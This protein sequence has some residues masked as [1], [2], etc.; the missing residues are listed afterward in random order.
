MKITDKMR[1]DF[2]RQFGVGWHN[3]LMESGFFWPSSNCTLY[4][5]NSFRQ[6]IDAAIRASRRRKEK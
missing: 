3:R 2:V 5:G 4:A 6:A 1:L